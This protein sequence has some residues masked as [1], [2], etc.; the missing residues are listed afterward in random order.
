[1]LLDNPEVTANQDKTLGLMCAKLEQNGKPCC[2]NLI[3]DNDNRFLKN[4]ERLA[5]REAR[6]AAMEK[7][8]AED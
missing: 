4:I 7:S 8:Q 2:L 5:R 3:T 1:M 6:E